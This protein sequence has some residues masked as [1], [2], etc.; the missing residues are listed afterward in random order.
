MKHRQLAFASILAVAT[1]VGCS[2]SKSDGTV[3]TNP[4][5]G[6]SGD[7]SICPS[8][9]PDFHL[10]MTATGPAGYTVEILDATPPTPQRAAP[11]GNAWKIKV[12]GPDGAPVSSTA[13]VGIGCSM[14]H[15]NHG[16]GPNKTVTANGDGTFQVDQISFLMIGAWKIVFDVTDG[17]TTDSIELPICVQ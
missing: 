11:Q 8:S 2:S 1:A 13:K 17:A 4:G 9:I 10:K 5:D 3:A 14:V 6:D 16:C 12:T 7:Y 15:A